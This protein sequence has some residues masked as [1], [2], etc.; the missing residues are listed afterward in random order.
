[1]LT[2][3]PT[4][5]L[6]QTGRRGKNRRPALLPAGALAGLILILSIFASAQEFPSGIPPHE[7]HTMVI[8]V[9][10]LGASLYL[11]L[12][13]KIHISNLPKL[14]SEGSY[15]EGV[16]GVYPTVTYPSHTTIVTGRMPAE[17]GIYS[18][19]SSR[20][21]GK[22]SQDWFWFAKAIKVPTLWDEAEAHHL[23]TGATF[24]PVTAGARIYWIAPEIWDPQ[25]PL[26]VDPSYVAKYATPGLLF[27]AL[28][29]IGPPQPGQ[30]L[31]VMRSRLAAFILKKY[32]PNLL[33]VHLCDL[34]E[35]EHRFGPDSP[36][37]AAT[38]KKI[39]GHIGELLAADQAAGLADS[40][41]VFIVSDH[42]FLPVGSEIKPNVL[43]VKAGLLT[44]DEKGNVTGGRIAT[45]VDGGSFFIYW[46]P[47]QDLHSEVNEALK[48]L[49][50]AGA[51]WAV[52]DRG[53]LSDL[54]SEPAAQM[55][56]EAATGYAFGSG[57]AG[58]LISR[59]KSI[60][61]TH[62]Y[63]PFRRE[64]EASFIAWGPN[65]RA[66]VDLHTIR[67]TEIAPTILKA[68]GIDDPKFGDEPPLT[69]IFK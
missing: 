8:S 4:I 67:M 3:G 24:W 34:D 26:Q 47:S 58:D 52:L 21:A 28:L 9:D 23:T 11:R 48:P 69:D 16:L 14:R 22:N 42:G 53:A 61:G 7:R 36:Q 37:V 29:E 33:L 59:G 1:M 41:D 40:T 32:K 43:L 10:G 20:E 51:L 35:D 62:G 6:P 15:A 27:E 46:P 55:A 39:D 31:D 49:R 12:A 60:T 63:L 13:A 56:L 25:K 65:I 64:L 54:G 50:D 17:H 45:V 38:L 30:E 2:K 57:A 68:M 19:L 18:N 44:A 66:G 5:I